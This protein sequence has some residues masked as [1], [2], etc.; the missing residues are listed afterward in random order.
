MCWTGSTSSDGSPPVSAR[1]AATSNADNQTGSNPCLTPK[2]SDPGSCCCTKA[3]P[4]R[5]PNRRTSTSCLT[6]IGVSKSAG[7]LSSSFTACTS[8]RTTA[9]FLKPSTGSVTFTP[10]RTTRV[11]SHRRHDHFMVRRDT[12]LGTTPAESPTAASK[13]PTLNFLQRTADGFTNPTNFAA[14][15]ILIALLDWHQQPQNPQNRAGQPKDPAGSCSAPPLSFIIK[16][17]VSH[18]SVTLNP[19]YGYSRR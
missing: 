15:G 8:L 4:S 12:G 3:T 2:C 7:T 1:C 5:P 6:N 16:T 17:P 19:G 9:A 18:R 10:R 14:R 11:P 13:A